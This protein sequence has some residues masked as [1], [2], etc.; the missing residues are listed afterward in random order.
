M[1]TDIE[2]IPNLFTQ[3]KYIPLEGVAKTT[4]D[5]LLN[6]A[7]D[8]LTKLE[9][10]KTFNPE[11]HPES[12]KQIRDNYA[13][14]IRDSYDAYFKHLFPFIAYGRARGED[15]KGLEQ[16][17]QGFVSSIEASKKEFDKNRIM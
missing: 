7:S 4:M 3:L 10:V 8:A 14:Q 12:P 2:R 17:A 9:Q 16:Q 13:N 1:K 5:V 11:D 15:L 6:Q